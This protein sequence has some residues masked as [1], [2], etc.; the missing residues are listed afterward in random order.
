MSVNIS[1]KKTFN[2]IQNKNLPGEKQR[3][4][5]S[6][7]LVD[8]R[9]IL[10][11]MNSAKMKILRSAAFLIRKKGFNHTGIQEILKTAGVPK[12]SF[13]YYFKSKEELGIE[14]IDFYIEFFRAKIEEIKSGKSKSGIIRIKK[15]IAAFNDIFVSENYSG[16]CPLG[17]LAQEMGDLNEKFRQKVSRAFEE[18]ESFVKACLDDAV[19]AGE[20]DN[21]V[22]TKKTAQLIINSW[23]GAIMRMKVE[24]S[25]APIKLM[26]K[27]IIDRLILKKPAKNKKSKK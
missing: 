8:D 13:Y 27:M 14:L 23:E 1:H 21:S 5:T 16:G 24:K 22:N 4:K 3:R 26:E 6:L 12:G 2:A 11:F 19:A 18:I 9:S 17:N 20:I 25:L 10:E 15:F 7:T